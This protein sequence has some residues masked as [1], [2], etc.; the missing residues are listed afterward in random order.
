MI[1]WWMLL[2]I[3]S[4]GAACGSFA[5][6]CPCL[7]TACPCLATTCPYLVTAERCW[8]IYFDVNPRGEWLVVPLSLPTLTGRERGHVGTWETSIAIQDE[9]CA[10]LVFSFLLTYTATARQC[11]CYALKTPYSARCRYVI[12]WKQKKRGSSF[13]RAYPY[14]QAFALPPSQG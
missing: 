5:S 3:S 1:G 4:L 2:I 13:L 6:A 12:F 7:V 11:L 14:S 9:R 10:T 8:C